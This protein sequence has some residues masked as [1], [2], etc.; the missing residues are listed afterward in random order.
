MTNTLEDVDFDNPQSLLHTIEFGVI[1][2]P[3]LAKSGP[4]QGFLLI[5]SFT[6]GAAAQEIHRFDG[7]LTL[8]AATDAR[9]PVLSLDLL[10]RYRSL[11]ADSERG[12]WSTWLMLYNKQK[13]EFTHTYL[14][15]EEDDGWNALEGAIPTER[16]QQMN[17]VDSSLLDA[18]FSGRAAFSL[19]A[20]YQRQHDIY[21]PLIKVKN[22][23]A[24]RLSGGWRITSP[25]TAKRGPFV[26]VSDN[27]G[28]L[29]TGEPVDNHEALLPQ[30][31]PD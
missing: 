22:F 8:P 1:N 24:E 13:D 18:P 11:T 14:W 28:V 20:Q 2:D 7:I 4:W 23:S 26:L 30:V 27:T 31:N 29:I 19:Y 10:N 12:P 25:A 3:D 16:V 6:D 15:P 17:P 5:Q 9:N 21:E